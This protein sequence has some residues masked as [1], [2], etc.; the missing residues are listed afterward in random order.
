MSLPVYEGDSAILKFG[1]RF[2]GDVLGAYPY[3]VLPINFGVDQSCRQ[4]CTNSREYGG[5]VVR[6]LDREIRSGYRRRFILDNLD[7]AWIKPDGTS[8]YHG[9]IPVG[10]INKTDGAAY[11]YNHHNFEILYYAL[12]EK[13]GGGGPVSY[14][15]LTLPTILLV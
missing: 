15:H 5:W 14:T 2:S 10:Y 11:I 7:A 12:P 9:G 13:K 6:R 3:E 1:R 4:I 8:Q